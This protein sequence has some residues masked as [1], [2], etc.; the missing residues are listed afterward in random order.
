V[1][2]EHE[3][4]VLIGGIGLF[5]RA[6]TY[7]LGSLHLVTPD[8]LSQPTPCAGWDLRTLLA[9]MNDSLIALQE[10][11]DIGRVGLDVPNGESGFAVD[12]VATLRNRACQ[13][14]G[15]WTN[16][17]TNHA[18]S[19]AG[20]TLTAAIVAGTGAIEVAVHGWDVAIACG[21]NRP[22]PRSL[23]EEMLDLSPLL[24]TEA[25]RPNRFAAPVAVPPTAGPADRLIAFLGRH[26]YRAAPNGISTRSWVI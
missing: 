18:V 17:R 23:A 15:A 24:V 8:A 25:D 6:I 12:A 19:I 21:R 26:P 14:L 10:A 5:E 2:D 11:A 4:A 3:R 7:M 16:A 13:L 1:T 20:R 9:H 22:I